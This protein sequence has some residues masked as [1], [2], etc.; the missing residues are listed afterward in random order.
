[1]IQII[2]GENAIIRR[3]IY[4]SDGRTPILT[5]SLVS[6]KVRIKD[7]DGS[8]VLSDEYPSDTLRDGVVPFQIEFELTDTNSLL[9]PLGELLFELE[10]KVP[11]TD[12]AASGGQVDIIRDKAL[13]AVIA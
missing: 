1:M 9:L 12:F 10:L 7:A 13:V 11:D 2:K 8:T 5:A 6:A 4:E 3:N